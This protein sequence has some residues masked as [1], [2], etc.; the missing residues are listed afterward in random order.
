MPGTVTAARV[1][2][3]IQLALTALGL[4][5]ILGV[6]SVLGSVGAI[7]L[8]WAVTVFTVTL[9]FTLK[10]PGAKPGTRI[11]LL[12]IMAVQIAGGVYNLTVA[13]SNVSTLL[14]LALS[15]AVVLCLISGDAKAYFSR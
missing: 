4:V 6:L 13:G 1:L 9:I 3:W 15:G 12:V 14:G 10:I 5:F 7:L 11:A 8:L 2:L